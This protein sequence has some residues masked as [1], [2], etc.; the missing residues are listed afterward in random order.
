MESIQ[1]PKSNHDVQ[2]IQF[3]IGDKPNRQPVTIGD[4][5]R[6]KFRELLKKILL[7]KNLVQT[8]SLDDVVTPSIRGNGY[9]VVGMGFSRELKGKY[10]FHG[11]SLEYMMGINRA[12]LE[13]TKRKNPEFDFEVNDWAIP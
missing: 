8:G 11:E 9:E 2:V 13:D 1:I 3:Y 7:E 6:Q 4:V 5:Y 12:H 10:F